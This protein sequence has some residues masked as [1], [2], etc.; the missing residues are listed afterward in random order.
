MPG[1]KR[2]TGRSFSRRAVLA[3]SATALGISVAGCSIGGGGSSGP[4]VGVLEDRSG[5]FQLNGTSKWQ[6]TRLAIE[7]INE[8]GGILG[9][10]V[11]IVDPDPQS[12]NQRYQELTERLILQ[13]EVDALWA[14][15]S[16][17]TREAIR[18]IINE[19]DQ[20]Y[21][22]T[23]QYEGGVCDSTIFPVGATAPTA[24]DRHPLLGRPV[25]RRHL[26]HRRRLQL[27]PTLWGLGERPRPG[28][29]LQRRRRRVHYAFGDRL[30]VGH[31]PHP[32]GGPRFHHVD[33]RRCEPRE[34]LRP[35]GDQRSGYPDRDVDGD[36]PGLRAQTLRPTSADRRLLRRQL[37]G[38]TGR[39][40]RGREP[41]RGLLQPV[42]GRELPQP[43]GP[44]QLLLGVPLAGCRRRG[45]HLRSGGCHR[46]ARTGSGYQRALG[47]ADP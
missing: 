21:F 36:G 38:R 3:S 7:E 33:A 10:E 26:H 42:A 4:T 35:A 13:D 1:G 41:R 40:P 12:D 18:P 31:Q 20:L 14:G 27:R 19:N 32:A 37:H 34:F 28:E 25:R 43:G 30:L 29:R 17:A 9:E 5:N 24:G 45:R 15:Y 11:E 6:A 46:S 2:M 22:Y 44:E 8:E 23:T 39:P 16:S 47:R